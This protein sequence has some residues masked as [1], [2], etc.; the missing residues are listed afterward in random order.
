MISPGLLKKLKEVGFPQGGKS[1]K[2]SEYSPSLLELIRECGPKFWALEY[3]GKDKWRAT[4]FAPRNQTMDN[5][6]LGFDAR[7]TG[8]EEAVAV[9]YVLLK[10]NKKP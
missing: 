6:F 4:S 5:D 2:D 9:L 8:P 10:Q 7:G 3:L 1:P